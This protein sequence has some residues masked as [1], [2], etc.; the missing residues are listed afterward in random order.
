MCI[1]PS[2]KGFTLI[3]L[4]VVIAIIAVL[5]A[6]LFPVFARAREKARQSTCM[7]NQRQLAAAVM[8]YAQDHGGQMLPNLNAPWSLSLAPYHEDNIYDCPSYSGKGSSGAPEYGYNAVLFDIPLASIDNPSDTMLTAD[9]KKAADPTYSYT[10]LTMD[11]TLD[12]RHA[13]SFMATKVDGSVMAVAYKSPEAMAIALSRAGI[14]LSANRA[15]KQILSVVQGSNRVAFDFGNAVATDFGN[16]AP[17]GSYGPWGV[18]NKLFD[19]DPGSSSDGYYAN[20]TGYYVL[21]GWANLTPPVV[22][23]K[24]TIW[25]RY[26]E[27]W[28]L[29]FRIARTFAD[30]DSAA[31]WY[32]DHATSLPSQGIL[33][34]TNYNTVRIFPD[35]AKMSLTPV[36]ELLGVSVEFDYHFVSSQNLTSTAAQ[37]LNTDPA[38]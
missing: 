32:H 16:Y 37:A 29:T 8:M 6:I 34:V 21:A 22:P 10:V 2:K 25:P 26:N 31:A 3:E 18:L 24:V 15:A 5:A 38:S 13:S 7:S 28:D 9:Y 36:G 20:G 23:T 4:L 19:M 17:W 14:S 33:T 1:M 35:A 12:P 30:Y 27:Q 11:A